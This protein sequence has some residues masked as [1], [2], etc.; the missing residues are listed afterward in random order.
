M[1][2][3]ILFTDLVNSTELLQRA[4]DERARRILH[5]HHRLLREAVAANG[6]HEV[7]WLGDGLMVAF[8]SAA[9]AVRCAIAMQQA[10][11]RPV[12]GERLA[13]RVGV[14]VGEVL[15][16]ESD[17]VGG[18]VVVARRLCDRAG[19]GEILCGSLVVALLHGRQA[20]TFRDRG[21]LELKGLPQPVAASEVV[22]EPDATALLAH[23]P[24]V[25]RAAEMAQL[26]EKLPGLRAGRGGLV[27][28]VGEPGI[29]K[30][31]AAEEFAE[32]ARGEGVVVLWGHCFEGEWTPP[33]GPFVEA[34]GEYAQAADLDTLGQDLGL[35][36]PSL[37]RLVPAIRRRLPK[38]PDPVRLE[39]DEERVRLLDAVSQ[40]LIAVAAR[41]PLVLVLDDLHWADRGTLTLLRH[42]A[43][44]TACHRLLLI[45]TYRDVE[46]D[47]QHPLADALAVVR[48]EVEYERLVLRGLA[49]TDVGMLLD[50][51]AEADVG[52]ALT[53][54]ISA[55]TNGNPFFIREVL[56]HLAEGGKLR[57][58]GDRWKAT[59]PTIADLGIP[60]GLRQV[61]TRRLARLSE[62]TNRLLSAASAFTGPFEF[63]IVMSVAG[64]S[65]AAGLA[66]L[67]EALGAQ[68]I[69][70]ADRPDCYT[71]V[72]ALIRHTLYGEMNPSRRVRLHRHVAETME[73]LHGERATAR[74]AELA[75]QYH[76]S[77]VLPGAERG[78][79]YAIAAAERAEAEAAWDD[80]A[81]FL[82]MALE[83]MESHDT[84]RPRVQAR[85]GLALAWAMNFV[86]ALRTS[87]EAATQI[88]MTEG[89]DAAADYLAVLVFAL[90]ECGF[91]AGSDALDREGV[92]E[93]VSLVR[94]GLDYIGARRD[95]A[96]VILRSIDIIRRELDDP[97][98]AGIA[99][100]TPE[101]REL[102]RV[103]QQLAVVPRV[104]SSWPEALQISS[105]S[106]LV[107][108][109][110][111]GV[112]SSWPGVPPFTYSR[113]DLA[114][115]YAEAE[116]GEKQGR[117]AHSA[118]AW[119]RVFRF[120][121]ARGEFAQASEARRRLPALL[122]RIPDTSFVYN[123]WTAAEDEWR[124]ARDEDWGAPMLGTRGPSTDVGIVKYYRAPTDAAVA[125]S[126]ARMG[127]PDRALRRL[128]R[129]II[130]IDKAPAW[131]ENYIRTIC[132]AAETLWLIDRT[133]FV[134]VIERNLR[135]KIVI[136]VHP[137]PMMDGRLALARV[138]ALQGR[139]EEACEWFAKARTVLEEL[140][141]RPLRAIV[142]FDEALTFLRRGRADDQERARPLLA[143]ALRAFR[144]I[145]MT[146][147][148]RRAQAHLIE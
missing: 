95:M 3:T 30:T 107:G 145:G 70:A 5:A 57:Q 92:E 51:I 4:G 78:V 38:V 11:R 14:N 49:P 111:P 61:I 128:A 98:Y 24:F 27:M 35:G 84:R 56:I 29:G 93:V 115:A 143:A 118:L 100:D 116:Q 32:I 58:E 63:A 144:E 12:E 129:V 127:T 147:W 43:R 22:Y 99:L 45:G 105:V 34:L 83:L 50:T 133:D 39:P 75:Y 72:H 79:T 139:S 28:L 80:A 6:G 96:W 76:R 20:F 104:T 126:H 8:P 77:A 135:E 26:A 124:M 55:E 132:D 88:A 1:T 31:R 42:I 53:Q 122:D 114:V 94:L 101:R 113:G 71:F 52:Q 64:V 23:T 97:D 136:D 18:A 108:A 21:Q 141:A 40:F 90:N 36:A 140:E 69:R 131:A 47:P 106:V 46:L 15:R 102:G 123:H 2:T 65:E 110:V 137:Y 33:Y 17:Y 25:G 119:T 13:I 67:D 7:K 91:N 146:G 89:R 62:D 117:L 59:A 82:R 66:A 148:V 112:A 138:C 142:D 41:S 16:D 85:M 60:E 103:C 37:A 87:R 81:T 130:A 68:L 120:H 48:R 74:A 125:R 44:T 121:T 54:A 19:G 109:S 134:E 9:D 86:P 73:T 10:A